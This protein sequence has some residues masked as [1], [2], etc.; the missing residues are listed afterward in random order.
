MFIRLLVCL[1]LCLVVSATL[2]ETKQ[3]YCGTKLSTIMAMFCKGRFLSMLDAANKKRSGMSMLPMQS[4]QQFSALD[5]MTDDFLLEHEQ[6][7]QQFDDLPYDFQVSYQ[8]RL[9]SGSGGSNS[10]LINKLHRVRR[11]D[12]GDSFVIRG[13][14]DECCRN[15]CS[16]K[17]LLS[18]CRVPSGIY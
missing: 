14:T 9:P 2:S 18:Y 5:D 8:N 16:L 6:Q 15:A 12:G 7:Q 3:F 1:Q 13:I 4:P 17:T 11:S 10:A